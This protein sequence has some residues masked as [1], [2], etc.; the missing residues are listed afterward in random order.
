MEYI[1]RKLKKVMMIGIA[2]VLGIAMTAC[3]GGAKETQTV[4]LKS[5]QTSLPAADSTLPEMTMITSEDE[6]AELN[7]T[8]LCDYDYS[9]V[10]S[11]FYTYAADGTAP[12]IA[13]VVLKKA[14]DA[15]DLM[16]SITDHNAKREGTM[17]SYTPEQVAMVQSYVLTHQENCVLY[18]VGGQNGMVQKA[19]QE[20]VNK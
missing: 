8:A 20:A 13:V 2:V 5:M 15:A 18:A 17:A 7:F 14:S 12:E 3:G 10:D 19:F 6:N 16:N 11:Y 9:K 4:D 1:M